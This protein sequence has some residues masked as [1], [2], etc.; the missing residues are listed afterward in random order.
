M[1]EIR[2]RRWDDP[3]EEGDG[4]RILVCRYRPRGLPKSEET[5]DEWLP[6]LG[7]SKDLHAAAYGKTGPAIPWTQYRLAYLKEM[8]S[9]KQAIAKLAERVRSG[10]TITLL[11][12][13]SCD[14]ESR[15]HRSLLKSLIEAEIG[16]DER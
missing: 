15:C 5:W 1:P 9:Q 6:D 2:T 3:N 16:K 7:P 4:W 11:C 13:S 10:E 14:R 12:S 8:L